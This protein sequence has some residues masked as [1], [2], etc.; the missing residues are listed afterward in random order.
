MNKVRISTKRQ[1]ILKI[2]KKITGLKNVITELDNRTE[3]FNSR[4]NQD[5][6]ISELD[7][8]AVEFI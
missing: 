1:K 5:E 6:K 4:L 8:R 3:G 2:M 7:D